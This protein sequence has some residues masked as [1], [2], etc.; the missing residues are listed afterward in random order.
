VRYQ[1]HGE[2]LTTDLVS[3]SLAALYGGARAAY[4]MSNTGNRDKLKLATLAD[5]AVG[6]GGL[7]A[8]N[9]VGGAMAHEVLEALGYAGFAGLGQFAAAVYKKQD[10]IPVWRQDVE[11]FYPH[12]QGKKGT[13][14]FR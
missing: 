14:S 8:K 10:N 3:A 5:M 7:V 13:S 11:V 6:A 4:A 9:Y 1:W 12:E 2:T